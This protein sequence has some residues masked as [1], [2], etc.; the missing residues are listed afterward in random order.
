[1]IQTKAQVI[2]NKEIATGCYD[3]RLFS[4]E[5]TMTAQP[6]Q[7][8]HALCDQDRNF[9]LR[10]PFSISRLLGG[11]VFELLFKVV[12]KGTAV[13]SKLQAR[14]LVDIIGPLGCGFKMS[15]DLNKVV[16]VAG[17]MGVAPLIFLADKLVGQGIETHV[18][19]GAA[20]K[21]ELL[22]FMV[23]RSIA[24][25]VLP[26]TEDGSLGHQGLVV[27]FLSTVIEKE[28]P[29]QIYACG[30]EP[31]LKKVAEMAM[32]YKIGCQVSLERRMACGLGACYSCVCQTKSGYKK[33]CA[34]GPV[35]Q[36]QEIVW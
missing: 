2:S 10:R 6:G 28:K 8:V 5:I 24:S 3:L 9:I 16:L 26:V 7:F 13:L 29:Q 20:S 22:H 12:G 1:M 11:N 32:E 18:L 17:G 30:P 27:D 33:V 21:E 23:L 15:E 25:R 19:Q 35:F 34:E 36:G 14:Q 4:P 31:M